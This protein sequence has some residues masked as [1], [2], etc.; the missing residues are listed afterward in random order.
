MAYEF[1]DEDNADQSIGTRSRIQRIACYYDPDLP[2]ND[3]KFVPVMQVRAVGAAEDVDDGTL[4][5]I[6]IYSDGTRNTLLTQTLSST[7]EI[8]CASNTDSWVR[9]NGNADWVGTNISAPAATAGIDLPNGKTLV[10]TLWRW[11]A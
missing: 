6:G 9:Y 7:V 5:I 2:V 4:S 3:R 10:S 8:P 11:R 1:F